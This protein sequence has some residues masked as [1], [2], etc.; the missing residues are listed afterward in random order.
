MQRSFWA[1][2]NGAPGGYVANP[3]EPL[4]ALIR[5]EAWRA[6]CVAVGEDLGSV[7]PGLRDRLAVSGLLG[8]A[9]LQ[10][11]KEHGRFRPPAAYRAATLASIGTH[12]TPTLRSE[13]H[14][15]EL[16]SLLR[17]TSATLSLKTKIPTVPS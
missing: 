1:P 7:P 16:Q 8:C 17:I 13:A 6:G 5:L 12:D 11:E 10:F 9:V 2:E 14:P 4:L 15:S 3:L